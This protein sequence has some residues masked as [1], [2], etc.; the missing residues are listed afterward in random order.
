MNIKK[1]KTNLLALAVVAAFAM[2]TPSAAKPEKPPK[3]EV[4]PAYYTINNQHQIQNKTTF[5]KPNFSVG[6]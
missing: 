6:R 3:L 5:Q 2:S 1:N 4:T